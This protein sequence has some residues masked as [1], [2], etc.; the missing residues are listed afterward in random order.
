VAV[1][2][3]P[4]ARSAGQAD[5][6]LRLVPPLAAPQDAIEVLVTGGSARIR[7]VVP[8]REAPEMPDT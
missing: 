6:R 8:V 5:F 2:A 1:I 4:A 3:E 7:A